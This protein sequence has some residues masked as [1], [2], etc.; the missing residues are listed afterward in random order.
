MMLFSALVSLLLFRNFLAQLFVRYSPRLGLSGFVGLGALLITP[1]AFGLLIVS[2]LGA[3]VG[4]FLLATYLSLLF[5]ALIVVHVFVGAF[6]ANVVVKEYKVTWFWTIAGV[7]ATQGVLL[8]PIVGA[9][10]VFAAF[11][12][13]V[14]MLVHHAYS[15]LYA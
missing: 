12:I 14:G 9:L 8:I 3:L 1:I 11:A 10:L 13:V 6:I 4:L 2:V 7:A 5:V 15:S